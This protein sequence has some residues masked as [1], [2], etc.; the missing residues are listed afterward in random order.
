MRVFLT[1]HTNEKSNKMAFP[2]STEELFKVFRITGAERSIVSPAASLW[3]GGDVYSKCV[4][5][6]I[7]PC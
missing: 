5:R 4:V 2:G 3:G 7:C 6:L 1:S